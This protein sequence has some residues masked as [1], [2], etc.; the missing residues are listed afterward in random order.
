MLRRPVLNV[1]W[2]FPDK[3]ELLHIRTELTKTALRQMVY[4]WPPRTKAIQKATTRRG[5]RLCA[6]CKL[7]F[8]HKECEVD[9]KQPV[10]PIDGSQ[11]IEDPDWNVYVER[12]FITKG[13]QVLCKPCHKD[14][15]EDE[16]R[17]RKVNRR[18][19]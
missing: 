19:K 8:N 12:L 13:W 15:S 16:N 11:D 3:A 14:K 17:I 6:K 1:N 5:Y 2:K 7:E 18:F 9:H 4:F 10:S